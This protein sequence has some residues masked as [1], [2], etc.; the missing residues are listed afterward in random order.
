MISNML[1]GLVY[2]FKEEGVPYVFEKTR[3]VFQ[4]KVNSIG[5][6]SNRPNNSLFDVIFINGCDSSVPHPIRYRVDHQMEQLQAAGFSVSRVEASAL[7]ADIVRH[8]RTFIIFRCPITDA[9]REFIKLAKQL[10]KRVI[11]DIDDLVID[12]KYT[13]LI[14]FVSEMDSKDKIFYDDGVVRMGETLKLCDCAITTTE[15][16][17]AEL[18]NYVPRVYVN[19]NTASESMLD[20]SERA[21]YRRDV[22]PYL[23]SDKV[24]SK[25]SKI[26]WNSKKRA[27]ERSSSNEIRIGYFSGSITHNADFELVLP[28]LIK[29]MDTYPNVTLLVGGELDVSSEL[30]R[31]GSRVITF[32]FCDWRRLPE[33]IASCDINIAPLEDTIFNRA[34]SENKWIEASLVKVPTVASNVGAFAHMIADGDT[35]F[36]CEPEDWFTVLSRLIEF[37]ELRARAAENSYRFCMKHCTT[38]CSAYNLA[39]IITQEQT[40]NLMMVLPSLN[41]SGGVLVALRHLCML[42]DA[43]VDVFIANTDDSHEWC[44]MFGHKIP[45]LNREVNS[46]QMDDCPFH[47]SIDVGVA[48][49]WDTLDFIKRYPELG[50]AKYL[51]QNFETDFYLPGDPLRISAN[52]TYLNNPDVEYL[53]I[54]PWC[55][56]WLREDYGQDCKL[57]PNGL[58]LD[59]FKPTDRDFC[60]DKIR[61]LVEGDCNSEYK[62]VDESFRIVELLDPKKFE[63]WYMSYTGTAKPF[64]RIDNNLGRVP[65]EKVGDIY[66]QCHI[67]LKTSI[68]ESFSY[69]P[70]EMMATGGFV[71]AVPNDG[72]AEFLRNEKNCLL[73]RQGDYQQGAEA[74]L[75][76]CDDP[77]LRERL[78]AGGLKTASSRDWS[79][80]KDQIVSM[81]A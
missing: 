3:K 53:T 14:P 43:G 75:R 24:S 44:D 31:F 56:D 80:L 11:Y 8:A 5:F 74:I 4:Q 72:N 42:Q 9:V 77:E 30:N 46:G 62:N 35:G 51:V 78:K 49:L 34:K 20:Y 38:V 47:A 19:R 37:P 73:Y 79:E 28:D 48:T 67:L 26:Y 70:L 6:C 60:S 32:P 65:H 27:A 22:L 40:A 39:R 64:Y 29:I 61:I 76:I 66:R 50:R 23:S 81:Y 59:L 1:E 21:L 2:T 52:A 55:R 12:T 45:V 7:S 41:T 33:K 68:L 58:E 17:A 16:L 57:V 36:L 63:I 18:K 69:P 25:D 10:N 15:G 54:S 71:V 13:D